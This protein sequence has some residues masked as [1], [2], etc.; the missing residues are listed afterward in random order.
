MPSSSQAALT[1]IVRMSDFAGCPEEVILVTF[2]HVTPARIGISGFP[3]TRPH[4]SVIYARRV[5]ERI[6]DHLYDV[7]ALP[8]PYNEDL[9]T[10][11][12]APQFRNPVGGDVAAKM[13]AVR[14]AG[15]SGATD[16]DP[17]S[18]RLRCRRFASCIL[19][20]TERRSALRRLAEAR[21]SSGLVPRQRRRPAW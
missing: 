5:L 16:R 2:L 13:N 19:S 17:F 1:K 11:I 21:R 20:S 3:Q 15:N 7:V 6:V 18:R 9:I 4:A 14:R 12:N 8:P 10:R